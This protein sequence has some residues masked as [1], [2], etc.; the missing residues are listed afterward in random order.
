MLYLKH[1]KYLNGYG[2][3]PILPQNPMGIYSFMFGGHLGTPPPIDFPS[4]FPPKKKSRCPPTYK[5]ARASMDR[6]VVPSHWS[7]YQAPC[8]KHLNLPPPWEEVCQAILR[9]WRPG[10]VTFFFLRFFCF[11]LH[12]VEKRRNIPEGLCYH[13]CVDCKSWEVTNLKLKFS[14][15]LNSFQTPNM[16]GS[17]KSGPFSIT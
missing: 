15:A 13:L 8:A 1:L 5:N 7:F 16:V 17:L 9:F 10:G 14:M 11:C 6:P 12:L 2:R 3:P 4:H